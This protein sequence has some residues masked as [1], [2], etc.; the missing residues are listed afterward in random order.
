MEAEVVYWEDLSRNPEKS[1]ALFGLT[2][3][4]RA[5]SKKDQA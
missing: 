4:L 3:S 2:K 5:P 1:G